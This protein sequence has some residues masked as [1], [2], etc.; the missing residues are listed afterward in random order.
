MT[1]VSGLS[2]PGLDGEDDMAYI[3]LADAKFQE[4]VLRSKQPVLVGFLAKWSGPCH[5]IAPGL[6]EMR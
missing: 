2:K 6:R 5:I 1:K 4:E 3:T